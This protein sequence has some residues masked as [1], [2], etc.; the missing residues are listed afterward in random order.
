MTQIGPTEHELN[1]K[2]VKAPA[3][4]TEIDF[5]GQTKAIKHAQI[6]KKM[7]S[8]PRLLAISPIMTSVLRPF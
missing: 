1:E 8:A 5:F 2:N 7:P 3:R 4:R 6:A